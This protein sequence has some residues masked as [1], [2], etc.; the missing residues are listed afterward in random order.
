MRIE[1]WNTKSV[2]FFS[3]RKLNEKKLIFSSVEGKVSFGVLFNFSLTLYNS[4]STSVACEK[5]LKLERNNDDDIKILE[6]FFFIIFCFRHSFIP[7]WVF[8][9][10]FSWY[11]L[12]M[13]S[14]LNSRPHERLFSAEQHNGV[15]N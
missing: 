13:A 8:S 6:Q 9:Y 11:V 15:K 5:R 4:P 3:C 1:V 7:T 14:T 10:F 12:L 2:F